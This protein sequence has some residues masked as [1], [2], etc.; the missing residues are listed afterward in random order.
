[1]ETVSEATSLASYVASKSAS[2][3]MMIWSLQ[4]QGSPSPQ[5]FAQ[6][7]CTALGLGNCSAS[8]M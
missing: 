4:K 8:M 7:I 3:G 6:A 2:G 1:M 5:T